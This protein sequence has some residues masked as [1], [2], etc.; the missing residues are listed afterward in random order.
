MQRRLIAAW[1]QGG[2]GEIGSVLVVHNYLDQS[3][4]MLIVFILSYL[5]GM[6]PEPLRAWEADSNE[7]LGFNAGG[8]G[9]G[10]EK[11]LQEEAFGLDWV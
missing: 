10:Q 7:F 5:I 6:I 9:K 11:S 3:N 8:E 4:K 1:T 2:D